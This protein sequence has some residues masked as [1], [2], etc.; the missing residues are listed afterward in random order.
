M[1]RILACV[2]VFTFIL[3]FGNL[4]W[5]DEEAASPAPDDAALTEENIASPAT[6]DSSSTKEN[7]ET[8]ESDDAALTEE[9]SKNNDKYKI[10]PGD[11]LEISVWKDES[12]M[13]QITVPP[14][15]V[16][17]FPIIGE[18]E[19]EDMTVA[20][21][22]EALTKKLVE[23][24]PDATVTVLLLQI[25]SLRAYV[26]GKVNKPGVYPIGMKTSVMQI[27][28]MAGGLNPFACP[29]DILIL[30]QK[31]EETTKLP[32]NYED[33][34]E[35]KSLEQNVILQSGDVVVVP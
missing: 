24:V 3:I 20:Q 27:L 11:V 12:L 22:R 16:I 28:T 5:A 21:L 29:E 9:A 13:R 19:A 26:I 4:A 34:A 14:D 2:L 8:Q 17:S 15:S 31:G 25:N 18:I 10:G 35:G 23:Y 6:D 30:R 1:K 7:A 32:F 33:V